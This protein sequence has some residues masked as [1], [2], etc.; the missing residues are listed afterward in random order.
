MG[1]KQTFTLSNNKLSYLIENYKYYIIHI[2][3]GRTFSWNK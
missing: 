2:E 3:F 1:I